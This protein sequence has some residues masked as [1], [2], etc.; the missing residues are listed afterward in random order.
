MKNQIEKL[1]IC[2]LIPLAVGAISSLLSGSGMTAFDQLNK[3]ALSPPGIVFPIVWTLLYTLMGIASYLIV[4]SNVS[5]K[6]KMTALTFY[7]W[8]L[9]V[10]FFW[11][12]FFFQF[13]WYLFS[14]IWL[15]LLLLLILICII[16]FR[17]ISKPASFLMMPYALWVAFAGY[18][19]FSIYLLN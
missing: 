16:L 6:D 10:N 8:Q 18:L 15:I 7:R 13:K 1:I 2:I 4:A 9:F 19:N 12:I 5:D 17:K 11:S 3:P 14:F